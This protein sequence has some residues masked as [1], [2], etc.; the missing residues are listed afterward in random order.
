M[1]KPT[2]PPLTKQCRYCGNVYKVPCAT[3]MLRSKYCS[4]ACRQRQRY[5][6]GDIDMA[7]LRRP[8]GIQDIHQE[9]PCCTCKNMY[10]PTGSSQRYCL[11]CAPGKT[12][13]GRI[14]RYGVTKPDWDRMLAAQDGLCAICDDVPTCVDHCHKTGR[15]RGLLCNRCNVNLAV[16]EN[17]V[18]RVDAEVYLAA[19]I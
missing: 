6:D 12:W 2:I 13:V 4:R 15:V 3:R 11:T 17:Y 5:L 8:A 7:K 1:S 14:R 9:R 16:L 18:W 19:E 10:L